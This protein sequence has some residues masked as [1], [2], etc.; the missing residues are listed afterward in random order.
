[1][2]QNGIIQASYVQAEQDEKDRILEQWI[3]QVDA[4]IEAAKVAADKDMA[5]DELKTK[6]V[7]EAQKLNL[8]QRLAF[9][10]VQPAA[11]VAKPALEPEGRAKPGHAFQQ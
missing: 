6:L 10:K 7:V 5:L 8:Q 3:A 4:Q 9:N 1:M 11:Q 2:R